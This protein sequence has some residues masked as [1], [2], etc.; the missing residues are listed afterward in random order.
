M[1]QIIL[2]HGS[3]SKKVVPEY[4]LGEERHNY[5]KGFYLT[6][7]IELAKE[8]AACRPNESN[9]WVHK[10]ILNTESLKILDF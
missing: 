9:G 7:D 10:Y 4:G 8:W 2:F 1:G 6:E 3:P 5:G